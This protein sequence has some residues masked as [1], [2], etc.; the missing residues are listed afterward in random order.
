M[1]DLL[2]IVI[3]ITAA[4]FL[5]YRGWQRIVQ[6]RSACG[7]CSHC[8]ANT[9]STPSQLVTLTLPMSHAETQRRG[10]SERG[11]VR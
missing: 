3:A 10:R 5:I 7:A 6:R 4:T 2:A 8:P 9:Q 1:Q 11:E